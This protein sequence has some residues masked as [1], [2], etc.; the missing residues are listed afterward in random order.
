MTNFN[1]ANQARLALKMML[2]NYHWYAGSSVEIDG[3]DYCVVI[4][5]EHI[6]DEIRKIIPVVYGNISVKTNVNQGYRK[7]RQGY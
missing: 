2:A 7:Q 5:L 1:L 4:Y 6:N 3:D